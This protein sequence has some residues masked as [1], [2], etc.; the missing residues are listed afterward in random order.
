MNFKPEVLD[1]NVKTY[2]GGQVIFSEGDR[3]DKMFIIL[4]GEVEILKAMGGSTAKTLVTLR[5]GEFFGEMALIEDKGRSATAL[6]KKDAKLLVMNEQVFDT[7]IETNPD[8]ALKMIKN[9]AL[10]LRNANKLLEQTLSGNATK[11]VFEGLAEY[12]VEKGV[13]TFKGYRVSIPEFAFWASQ[14]I[15]IPEKNIPDVLKTLLERGLI[16]TSAM[17]ENEVIYPKKSEG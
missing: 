13:S 3:G 6:C 1:K 5:K 2:T 12:A 4:D 9:L 8:F 7:V 11:T 10:R 17:G 16:V 14:H 15:G